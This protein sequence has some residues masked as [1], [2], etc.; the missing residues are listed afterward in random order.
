MTGKF[1][2]LCVNQQV[3]LDFV[4]VSVSKAMRIITSV[5]GKECKQEVDPLALDAILRHA[6]ENCVCPVKM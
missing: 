2:T 5:F 6:S 4:D 3:V 1:F